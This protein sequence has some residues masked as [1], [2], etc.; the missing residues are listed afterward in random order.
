[1]SGSNWSEIYFSF[2]GSQYP[3]LFF[4]T[5]TSTIEQWKSLFL[6]D[7]QNVM[8]GVKGMI[9]IL[10][11]LY[12]F[13]FQKVINPRWVVSL[14]LR[15]IYI[16]QQGLI[17]HLDFI[18]LSEIDVVYLVSQNFYC[19]RGYK[20]SKFATRHRISKQGEVWK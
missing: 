5:S 20:L 16:T 3:P 15:I 9:D 18:K 8:T 1:M 2:L 19:T 14:S 4:F 13:V 11:S 7:L 17:R 12:C 10:F 6:D